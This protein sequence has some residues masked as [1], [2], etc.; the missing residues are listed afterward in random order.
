M[1]VAL[2]RFFVGVT[3]VSVVFDL[4]LGL[5]D[6]AI[7]YRP[8]DPDEPFMGADPLA[9]EMLG[10]P[11]GTAADDHLRDHAAFDLGTVTL[12]HHAALR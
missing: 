1:G 6:L 7:D 5:N 10:G 8:P 9:A 11:I 2:W 3:P 4:G 12:W